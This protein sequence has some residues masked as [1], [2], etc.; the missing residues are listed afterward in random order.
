MSRSVRPLDC[1]G[2]SGRKS[3][4]FRFSF[5]ISFSNF[6]FAFP[7]RGDVLTS[8]NLTGV[9]GRPRNRRPQGRD[10]GQMCV[11]ATRRKGV[12]DSKRRPNRIGGPLSN[13]RVKV[14]IIALH[15]RPR[16]RSEAAMDPE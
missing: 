3:W 10:M 4:I 15:V 6:G 14:A 1:L 5:S 9:S 8:A 7:G 12:N 16:G 13:A 11:P 2:N